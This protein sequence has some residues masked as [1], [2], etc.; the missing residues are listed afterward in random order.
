MSV[1]AVILAAGFSRRL[2]RPK[3]TV[4]LGG[5][6]LVARAVRVATEAGLSPVL[7]VLQDESLVESVQA[8]GATALLN[9]DASEGMASSIRVGTNRAA[10]MNASGVVLMTCDQVAVTP[11]HLRVLSAQAD[12]TTGSGYAGKIGIP[13]YFPSQCFP[14][15]LGLR[16]D[17]GARDLLGS[18][19]AI[20]TETL[21][22]D[23]DT[24]ADIA[25]AE[26]F[27]EPFS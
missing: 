1:P 7:V 12:R 18:A 8:L 27:L 19:R 21:G 10:E 11:G 3:Q 22:F 16:G 24:E 5:E 9:L 14:V 15:L 2:G 13:A 25:R 20:L 17:T 4:V 6:T 23:V 26:T